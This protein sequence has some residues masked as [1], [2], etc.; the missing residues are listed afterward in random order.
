MADAE[1]RDR[2]PDPAR[3]FR[4]L[5]EAVDLLVAVARTG[6]GEV[7]YLNPFAERS[8]GVAAAEVLGR[9][10]A[11]TLIPPED[12]AAF[13]DACDRAIREASATER[14]GVVR[15]RDGSLRMMRW[16][17]RAIDDG[18]GGGA[19]ALLIVGRD[20][21][22]LGRAEE[23]L[24]QAERMAA[25]GQM[26]A[27]LAHES[28]NALQRSQACLEML[29]LQ[30]EDRPAAVDL[31]GRL[32]QAQD[33]LHRLYEDVREFAAPIHLDLQPCRLDQVWRR[34]WTNLGRA[35]AGR[36]ALLVE[37]AEAEALDCAVDAFRLEQVFANLFDNALA[38]APGS[39]R[40][41]VA[42]S[43]VEPEGRGEV[44]IVVRDDGP[45]L[46]P[47]QRARFFDAFFTTKTR[48][49]GLGTAIVKRIVEAHGGRVEVGA[50]ASGGAEVIL[51]IPRGPGPDA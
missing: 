23:R 31:I 5:A 9:G 22:D 42:V 44:R 25:I 21:T 46:T 48:G 12:R 30:V 38:A 51:T 3:A 29:A 36:D 17:L 28:R 32:Q 27:G 1:P 39:A 20:V 26:C 34:A 47:E 13:Q 16:A 35:R 7:V 37:A 2:S 18:L 11:E 43:V 4:E 45:G 50:S 10:L 8:T 41:E 19:P 15:R 14:D 24:L 6:S 40:V 49:T 33:D